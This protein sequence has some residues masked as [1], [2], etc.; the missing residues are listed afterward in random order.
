LVRSLLAPSDLDLGAIIRLTDRKRKQTE[1]VSGQNRIA[2]CEMIEPYPSVANPDYPRRHVVSDVGL[3]SKLS[4][5]IVNL[6]RITAGQLS[7]ISIDPSAPIKFRANDDILGTITRHAVQLWNAD[8]QAFK[9][10][11]G[12]GKVLMGFDLSPDGTTVAVVD[13]DE[14]VKLWTSDG[15]ELGV[16][17]GQRPVWAAKFSPNS[18]RLAVAE[19]KQ[20]RLYELATKNSVYL[21]THKGWVRRV[22]FSP[23]GKTI[24][25]S[26][27]N[28]TSKLWSLAGR[29]LATFV[30]GSIEFS[31]DGSTLASGSAD[32]TIKL[33]GT[34]GREIRTIRGHIGSVSGISFHP[35]GQFFAS[36]SNDGT[37]R[38]WNLNGDELA[39]FKGLLRQSLY[40]VRFNAKG[41]R[42]AFGGARVIVLDLDPQTV[43]ERGSQRAKVNLASSDVAISEPVRTLCKDVAPLGELGASADIGR[44]N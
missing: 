17:A 15:Q 30:G 40:D 7:R 43:F 33:W 12:H 39:R 11:E 1:S 22:T 23:D 14:H 10:F 34:N 28:R 31:P 16:L 8:G 21:G 25:S 32:G 37:M 19:D 4:P 6:D 27:D 5:L 3:C 44:R 9:K 41:N 13:R 42:I 24:A 29:E 20:V 36:A 38:L 35:D 2:R 18:Q 26:S